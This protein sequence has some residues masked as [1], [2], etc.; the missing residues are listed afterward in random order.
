[1]KPW[2]KLAGRYSGATTIPANQPFDPGQRTCSFSKTMETL[3]VNVTKKLLAMPEEVLN[4]KDLIVATCYVKALAGFCNINKILLR[5]RTKP[6]T[7]AKLEDVGREL[8]NVL[9]YTSCIIHAR[10]MASDGFDYDSVYDF[11][12][13]LDVVYQQDAIMASSFGARALIDL[14]EIIYVDAPLEDAPP[15]EEQAPEFNT[16]AAKLTS[17]EQ[18]ELEELING[19]IITEEEA[20]VVSVFAACILLCERLN[21]DIDNLC[22]NAAINDKL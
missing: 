3:I 7:D 18:E 21:M 4:D 9:F 14:V 11:G 12:M 6:L 15:L 2:P 1:M 8:A 19:D 17:E 10:D 13:N 22:Y 20:C 5:S 16:A